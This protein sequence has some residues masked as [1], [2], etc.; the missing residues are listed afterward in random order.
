MRRTCQADAAPLAQNF[1]C[2]GAVFGYDEQRCDKFPV[3]EPPMT[4]TFVLYDE[5]VSV[6]AWV[7][8][9]ASFR[10]WA[11]SEEFPESGRICYL[12]GEVWVDMSKEQVFWHNQ[13]KNEFAFVLTGLAKA[14]RRGRF[15]PDGVL[16]SNPR[17]DFTSQPDGTFVSHR[18]LKSK[19]VLVVE[20]AHDGFVE[21]QGAPEMVLEIVSESSVDK[22][23]VVLRDLYW[24]AGIR[25]YWIVDV[26]GDNLDFD[27]LR[28]TSKG[29]AETRKQSG[30][31][32]SAVFGKSFRL[33][34]REDDLGFPEFALKVR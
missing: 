7:D 11:H 16:L 26:R 32:K 22:D 25:E 1:N 14:G 12:N 31:L 6:P 4:T 17:A 29:Y 13:I 28:H 2:N 33:I 8:D 20:G 30:W 18:A 21:L 23:T 3:N 24:K 15:F 5:F 27:I 34:E 19:Q 9:L 10:R